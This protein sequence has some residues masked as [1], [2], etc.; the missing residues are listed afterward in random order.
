MIYFADV[1]ILGHCNYFIYKTLNKVPSNVQ[2]K[3]LLR[4]QTHS[5]GERHVDTMII[6][7]FVWQKQTGIIYT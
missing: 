2:D 6:L 1:S 3:L 7:V 4:Q 5:C